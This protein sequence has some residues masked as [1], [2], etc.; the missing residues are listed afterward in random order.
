M[1]ETVVNLWADIG[2][3][4]YWSDLLKSNPGV[5][6]PFHQRWPQPG[7]IGRK[8]PESTR[9]VVVMA[10]N[11]R[12]S[13]TPNAE[14]ADSVMFGLIQGHSALRSRDSLEELFAM[15]HDFMLGIRY[16]PAW[17]PVSAVVRYLRL[18][19]DNIAYLNLIPLATCGDRIVPAF[20]Q[21]FDTSTR[22]QLQHLRPD[23]IVVFGKGAYEKFQEIGTDPWD[24]R[25]IQQRNYKDAPSVREWLV[26]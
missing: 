22:L 3:E 8:Y 25:Y 18:E 23:K 4:A 1:D 7:F 2:S 10:Q 12:G 20:R 16:K 9:R 17:R 11:P 26:S 19:L 14:A 6:C 5:F 24:V 21:A 15:M 13:N